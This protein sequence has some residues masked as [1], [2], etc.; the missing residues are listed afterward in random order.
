V[1]SVVYHDS[2]WYPRNADRAMADVLK[3]DWGRL[4]QA[5]EQVT[6]DAD[7]YPEVGQAP[8]AVT[9][10]GAHALRKS[11]GILGTC[12]REAPEFASRQR[13]RDAGARAR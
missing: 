11:V 7:G 3:S 8:A 1:A 5:W 12:I 13:R 2:F 9:R 4:F 10:L 6:A